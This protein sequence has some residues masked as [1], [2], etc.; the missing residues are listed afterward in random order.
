MIKAQTLTGDDCTSKVGFKH[1]AMARDL[2]QPLTNFGE[3]D[4]RDPARVR[5]NPSREALDTR[6]GRRQPTTLPETSDQPRVENHT[7]FRV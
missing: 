1:A 3:M 5:R 6:P 2:E 7:S 4:T